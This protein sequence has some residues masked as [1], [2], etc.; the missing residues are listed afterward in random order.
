MIT[1]F[2]DDN[3]FL[4]FTEVSTTSK[5]FIAKKYDQFQQTIYHLQ[6][7]STSQRSQINIIMQ[8]SFTVKSLKLYFIKII[9]K[10]SIKYIDDD[11]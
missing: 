2:N 1:L 10:E 3:D 8:K 5:N 9:D 7:Q 6:N 4:T 11:Y